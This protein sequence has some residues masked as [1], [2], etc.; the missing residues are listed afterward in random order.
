MLRAYL[1]PWYLQATPP[2][3]RIIFDGDSITAGTWGTLPWE[4]VPYQVAHF[5]ENK[6]STPRIQIINEAYPGDKL[7]DMDQEAI[8]PSGLDAM[9]LNQ[10]T[11]P[12]SN[13]LLIV[14]GGTNDIGHGASAEETFQRLIHYLAQRY[15]A[16]FH[17]IV[18]INAIPRRQFTLQLDRYN[19]LMA[20]H[21][22]QLHSLGVQIIINTREL[23]MF[24]SAQDA[25]NPTYYKDG[26]HPTPKGNERLA[27]LIT[28]KLIP[29]LAH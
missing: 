10:R 12:T 28:Q 20:S 22:A 16:C 11:I 18:L 27:H 26:T 9:L 13:T 29:L 4:T 24:Q 7:L 25:E 2:T 14:W 3:T 6:H 21:Q 1:S 8:R 19:A 17:N 5:L 15:Q 23:P